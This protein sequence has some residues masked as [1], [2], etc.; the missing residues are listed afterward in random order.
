M[1]HFVSSCIRNADSVFDER[2]D[3]KSVAIAGAISA[4]A[5]TILIAFFDSSNTKQGNCISKLKSTTEVHK[6]CKTARILQ[7]GASCHRSD[8]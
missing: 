3:I 2:I 6:C 5:L 8:S 4:A 1:I 7:L